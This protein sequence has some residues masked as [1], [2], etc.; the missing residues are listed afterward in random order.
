MSRDKGCTKIPLLWKQKFF[1]Q[2]HT[3]LITLTK[4]FQNVRIVYGLNHYFYSHCV[5]TDDVLQFLL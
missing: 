1:Q 3:K 5:S 2:I 4:Y